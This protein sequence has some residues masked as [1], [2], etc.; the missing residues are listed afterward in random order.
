MSALYDLVNVP[1]GIMIDEEGRIVRIDEGTYTKKYKAGAL[2]FGTDEYLPLLRD[3][4]ANGAE[5]AVARSASEARR[6]IERP[7]DKQN[8]AQAAFRLGV[9]FHEQA[10]AERADRYWQMAQ[11]L[12]PESWNYHRQDW[13]F[14]PEEAGANW[15]RKFQELDGKPYYRPMD[16]PEELP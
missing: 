16:L 9:Y 14:T 10:D 5:S 13:S 7:D 3:W 6:N 4:V 15:L 8:R 2:E 12:H 1:T 11:E